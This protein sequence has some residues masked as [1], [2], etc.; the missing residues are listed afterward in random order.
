MPTRFA[1]IALFIIVAAVGWALP[2]LRPDPA[3]AEATVSGGTDTDTSDSTVAAEESGN[4]KAD[5][6]DSSDSEGFAGNLVGGSGNNMTLDEASDG[7]YYATAS[8]NG[9][10]VDFLVDTGASSIALT[11]DDARMIGLT[12]NENNRQVIG[13][14]ASGNVYGETVMLDSV[15]LGGITVNN[16][17]AAIIHEGL[18]K[19]LLGQAFLNKAGSVTI[20]DGQ[21]VIS[22]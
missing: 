12:V 9:Q 10:A 20:K 19:S 3:Q 8:V 5:D 18:D 17:P 13:R 22:E 6:E 2:D 4:S 15:T 16:I 21:M 1:I 11:A 14:G 7:H